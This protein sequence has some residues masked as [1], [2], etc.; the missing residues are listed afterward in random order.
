LFNLNVNDNR[1]F[2]SRDFFFPLR[3][4]YISGPATYI[5]SFAMEISSREKVFWHFVMIKK[6]LLCTKFLIVNLAVSFFMFN[7]AV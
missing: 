1:Y 2:S 4:F 3:E 6:V 7:F 5:A